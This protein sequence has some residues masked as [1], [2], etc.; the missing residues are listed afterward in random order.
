LRVHEVAT[1]LDAA[2]SAMEVLS[3]AADVAFDLAEWTSGVAD[4]S[5]RNRAVNFLSELQGLTNVFSPSRENRE[6]AATYVT[7][8]ESEQRWSEVETFHVQQSEAGLSE[9]IEYDHLQALVNLYE[10]RLQSPS[11]ALEVLKRMVSC[12]PEHPAALQA[13]MNHYEAQGDWDSFLTYFELLL[14]VVG[15]RDVPVSTLERAATAY[16]TIRFD[17]AQAAV[18]ARLVEARV[19]DELDSGA[20]NRGESGRGEDG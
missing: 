3:G 14:P 10:E 9:E 2:E 7:L 11:K 16:E 17:E 4:P 19:L 12:K 5:V 8:L 18:M 1:S 13:L 20:A 15:E 6:P